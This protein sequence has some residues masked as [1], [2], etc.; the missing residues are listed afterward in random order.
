VSHGP[1]LSLPGD[2]Q[3]SDIGGVVLGRE[4]QKC[5]Q[6]NLTQGHFVQ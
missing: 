3:I 4:K 6:K 5:M 1:F 2:K